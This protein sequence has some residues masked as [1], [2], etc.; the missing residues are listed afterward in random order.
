MDRDGESDFGYV[1]TVEMLA[2]YF[3]KSL[4]KPASFKQCAA[5]GMIGIGLGNRLGNGLGNAIGTE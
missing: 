2:D 3:T 4:P 1:A 5:M